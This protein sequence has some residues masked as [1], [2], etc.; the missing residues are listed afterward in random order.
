MRLLNLRAMFLENWGLKLLSLAFATL[1]WLFVVGEKRSE[2]SLSA[3]LE[4]V[5]VPANMIVVSRVP[6]AIRLRLNGPS[7]LLATVNPSQLTV[8]LDLEGVQPG[9]SAFEILPARLDLPRGV[10]VT[11]ISPSVITLEAD[12]KVRKVL[13]LKARVRGT[14]AEGF[15]VAEVRVDPL[16]IEVEGADRALRQLKEIATE[17]LDVTGLEGSA[18]RPVELSFPDPTVRAA[19]RRT[20]RVE[21][22]IREMR[23]EREFLQVPVLLPG[24]G[25]LA[26]PASVN[27]KVAGSVRVLARLT[28]KDLAVAAE[29]LPGLPRPKGPVR[30][31]VGAL[32]G[33]EILAVQPNAVELTAPAEGTPTTG[34]P[35]GGGG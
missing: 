7:T 18:V 25:W 16:Q 2:V 17:V 35:K 20:V 29:P 30:V 22:V 5:R 8:R 27:V 21:V 28:A 24:P 33:V 4:L 10:E 32:P 19:E 9:I 34:S 13:P 12:L 11:Y 1:L 31:V 14:P 26:A 15:E 6:E 23:G 3:P